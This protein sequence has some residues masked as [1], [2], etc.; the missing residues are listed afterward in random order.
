MY[1]V[2]S[3]KMFPTS[4]P[5]R[6]ITVPSQSGQASPSR[7]LAMSAMM[8]GVKSRGTLTLRRWNPGRL[9]PATRFGLFAAR[10]S[11][12][13]SASRAPIGEP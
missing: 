7:T 13:T 8:S 4:M 11:T 6:R 1:F 5:L 2:P 12:T 9:A 3:L 10:A